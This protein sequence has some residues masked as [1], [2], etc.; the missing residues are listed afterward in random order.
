MMRKRQRRPF[1]LHIAALAASA[2]L[3]VGHA[4]LPATARATPF[5]VSVGRMAAPAFSRADAPAPPAAAVQ[6]PQEPQARE[7]P[8]F[9][10]P[11]NGAVFS[12]L[13]GS[14]FSGASAFQTGAALAYF[15]GEKATFGF[16]VE[17][18]ITFG[19]GGRVTQ[20]LG[21]FVYQ[22][23]ARTS[24]FVPYFAGGGGY[25]RANTDLPQR[26]RDVLEGFGIVPEPQTEQAPFAH[27]GGGLRFYIKP[28]LAFRAD[29]RFAQVF[30]DLQDGTSNYPMRRIA[31][32]LSWDF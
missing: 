9:T 24:K 4:L 23:G 26:T 13:G 28:T 18:D 19:P 25:L 7:R 29:V 32:M 27:F 20:V 30:L 21:S 14:V 8:P 31:G 2:G 12:I 3:L 22:T 10:D 6:E 1:T 5:F 16:E 15:F 11:A 17:A